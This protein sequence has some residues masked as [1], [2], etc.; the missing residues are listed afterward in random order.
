M[1]RSA[2]RQL[3]EEVTNLKGR[4]GEIDDLKTKLDDTGRLAE[5]LLESQR[6]VTQSA[7]ERGVAEARAKMKQAVKEGD[8]QAHEAAQAELDRLE[9]ERVETLAPE[10]EPVRQPE[11]PEE[12]VEDRRRA[13]RAKLDPDTRSWVEANAWFDNDLLLNQAMIEELGQVKTERPDLDVR[14]GLEEAKQ[15]VIEKFPRKFGINPVRDAAPAVRT[16][17]G[18]QRRTSSRSF[19]DIPREDQ[20][21][22]RRQQRIMREKG[23]EWTDEEIA[24]SHPWE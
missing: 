16:P 9:E 22:Y 20:E 6:R 3:S 10:P 2:N 11:P 8:E 15:R 17:S 7:Y 21:S 12:T 24:A 14:E 19:A 1:L 18:A 4:L 23:I 5:H 13:A